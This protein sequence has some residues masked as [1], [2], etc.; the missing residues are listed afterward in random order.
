MRGMVPCSANAAFSLMYHT[1]YRLASV[2]P[3]P[4]DSPRIWNDVDW[5]NTAA[6]IALPPATKVAMDSQNRGIDNWSVHH[7]I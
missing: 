3:T 1:R 4:M 2:P 6:N 5:S 7:S